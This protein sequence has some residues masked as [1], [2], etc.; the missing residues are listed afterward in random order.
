MLYVVNLIETDFTKALFA[1]FIWATSSFERE[2][3]RKNEFSVLGKIGQETNYYIFYQEWTFTTATHVGFVFN[4]QRI[5]AS[6]QYQLP[7]EKTHYV[8]AN[9]F[10]SVDIAIRFD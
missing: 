1:P 6:I 8:N 3:F 4:F 10:L 2:L 7:W 9:G 5:D